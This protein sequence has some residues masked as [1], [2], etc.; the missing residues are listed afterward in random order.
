MSRDRV[1]S[2]RVDDATLDGLKAY[3]ADLGLAV[4]DVVRDAVDRLLYPP[5]EVEPPVPVGFGCEHVSVTGD[6]V[7][8]TIANGDPGCGCTT[9]AVYPTAGATVFS[10]NPA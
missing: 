6:G 4:S 7:T 8:A 5:V 1:L 2:L 3:A 10:W 9:W